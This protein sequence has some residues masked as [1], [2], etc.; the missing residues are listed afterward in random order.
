[1]WAVSW[2]DAER[3]VGRAEGRGMWAG[4]WTCGKRAWFVGRSV[5]IGREGMVYGRKK[6]CIDECAGRLCGLRC[7]RGEG[8]R[9]YGRGGVA[10]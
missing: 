9:V 1:M 2:R 6:R 3:D 4:L 7:G 5:G 8:G 10:V